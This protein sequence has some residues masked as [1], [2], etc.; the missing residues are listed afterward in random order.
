M[1]VHKSNTA[2]L[3]ASVSAIAAIVLMVI[4]ARQDLTSE[5]LFWVSILLVVLALAALMRFGFLKD[6]EN[7]A[8]FKEA[9]GIAPPEFDDSDLNERAA[10]QALVDRVLSQ[11]A[12]AFHEARMKQEKH[13]RGVNYNDP[14]DAETSQQ[15]QAD[16]QAAKSA[17]WQASDIARLL[18]FTVKERYTGWL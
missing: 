17:F 6:K 14:Q 8:A 13:F 15:L 18:R 7:K 10:F 3:A 11:R 4:N 5:T 2:F 12:K 16:V 9:F 1:F